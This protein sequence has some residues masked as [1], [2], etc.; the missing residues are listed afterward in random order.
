MGLLPRLLPVGCRN[1]HFDDGEVDH[2]GIE[3]QAGRRSG[4]YKVYRVVEKECQHHGCATTATDRQW[5]AS[6]PDETL[7]GGYLSLAK[8]RDAESMRAAV[9]E[10]KILVDNLVNESARLAHE[11][12]A[13]LRRELG[14]DAR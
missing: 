10:D 12:A 4:E 2:I 3:Y 13:H 1:H 6:V 5:V 7:L 14:V 8:E 9:E 11:Q